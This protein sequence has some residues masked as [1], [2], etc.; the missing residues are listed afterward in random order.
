[1]VLIKSDMLGQKLLG[2]KKT[3]YDCEPISVG[4]INVMLLNIKHYLTE[5]TTF[6]T[7]GDIICSEEIRNLPSSII[8]QKAFEIALAL[9][10]EDIED[11]IIIPIAI[12][13]AR[14]WAV[15]VRGR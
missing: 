11:E 12:S 15:N 3:L 5:K 10:S 1:M 8:R 9:A 2:V 14:Y 6:M 7:T 4:T 13:G